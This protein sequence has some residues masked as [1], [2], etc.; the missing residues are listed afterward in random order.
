[1][2]VKMKLYNKMILQSLF[3]LPTLLK[4]INFIAHN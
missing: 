4:L 1:M 3:Y 2:Q